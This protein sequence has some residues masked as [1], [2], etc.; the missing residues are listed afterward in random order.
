MGWLKRLT[1]FT[2]IR[3]TYEPDHWSVGFTGR[4]HWDDEAECYVSTT[5]PAPVSLNHQRWPKY[6]D[7]RWPHAWHLKLWRMNIEWRK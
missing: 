3:Q 1:G 2:F 4:M 7:K 6:Q 5:W